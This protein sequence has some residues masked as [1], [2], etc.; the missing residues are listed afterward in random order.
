MVGGVKIYAFEAFRLG[1]SLMLLWTVLSSILIF[2][3]RETHC[4]QTSMP[5]GG[6][7]A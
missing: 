2:F 4:Q 3:T 1:F 7:T 6:R 5:S